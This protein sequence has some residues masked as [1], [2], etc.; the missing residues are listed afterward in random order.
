MN[1]VFMLTVTESWPRQFDGIISFTAQ[2]DEKLRGI[3]RRIAHNETAPHDNGLHSAP[4]LSSVAL[5]A[6]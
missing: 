6:E 2:T 3:M 5:T 4:A 1:K